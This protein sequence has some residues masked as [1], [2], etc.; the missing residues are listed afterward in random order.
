M[1][2]V[3]LGIFNNL[4]V[5]RIICGRRVK[6]ELSNGKTRRETRGLGPRGPRFAE[7]G[8]SPRGRSPPRRDAS[9]RPRKAYRSRYCIR[10]LTFNLSSSVLFIVYSFIA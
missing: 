10:L 5:S 7:R 2:F 6:V 3:L 1:K 8:R 9:Y 4:F